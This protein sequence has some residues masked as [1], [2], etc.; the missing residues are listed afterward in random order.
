[1]D[2]IPLC[3]SHWVPIMLTVPLIGIVSFWVFAISCICFF[4]KHT[5]EIC[6]KLF[7][8]CWQRS[9]LHIWLSAA[10]APKYENK[11]FCDMGAFRLNET[12]LR[13]RNL[14]Y[15]MLALVKIVSPNGLITCFI[16]FRFFI[17]MKSNIDAANIY[18]KKKKQKKLNETHRNELMIQRVWSS[19]NTSLW[20]VIIYY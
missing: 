2:R 6:R 13:K 17:N 15:W 5:L 10:T 18:E 7:P 16:F 20:N 4:T 12:F 14:Y 1:M 3:D 9:H 11:A 19:A 8:M